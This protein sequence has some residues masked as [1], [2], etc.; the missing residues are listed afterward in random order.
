ME[1]AQKANKVKVFAGKGEKH[2]IVSELTFYVFLFTF[3][4]LSEV[5]LIKRTHKP[6]G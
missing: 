6:T 3:N 1:T 2:K 5:I 4:Y